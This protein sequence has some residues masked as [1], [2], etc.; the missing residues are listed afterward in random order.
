MT[1]T[2]VYNDLNE[3]F[4]FDF[5]PCPI[6]WEE[7]DPDGLEIEWGQRNFVNPPYSRVKDWIQKAH[8]EWKKGKLVV[9]LIN[10]ITDTAAFHDYIY[11]KAELRFVRGRISFVNPRDPKKKSPNVKP[12]MIVVF[13]PYHM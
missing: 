3:E 6:D 10:A 5:D 8:K 1:P 7:G 9:M 13:K 2:D 11:G 4:I 12:S